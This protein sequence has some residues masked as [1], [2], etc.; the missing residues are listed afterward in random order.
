MARTLIQAPPRARRGE[1]IELRATIA[2][3]METGLRVDGQG[4]PVRRD[5][6][7]RF[8]CRYNAEVVFAA[9][10]HPAIAA[11]PQV[12]FFT[13]ATTSGRLEF[14]WEGDH[15]FAQTESVALEVT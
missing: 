7:T 6:L 2:H 14:S 1:V 13:V 11:N 10:W 3:P 8:T 4:R 15:G 9:E 12:R 5:I